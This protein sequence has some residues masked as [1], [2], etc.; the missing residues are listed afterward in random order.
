MTYGRAGRT[1]ELLQA[2]APGLHG[3]VLPPAFEAGNYGDEPAPSTPGA[4]LHPMPHDEHV[5][6]GWRSDRRG[7]LA[8]ALVAAARGLVRGAIRGG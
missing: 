7:E 3:R 5:D 1:L 4:V 6:G 8:R 2:F